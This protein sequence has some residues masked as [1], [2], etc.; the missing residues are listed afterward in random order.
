MAAGD[1]REPPTPDGYTPGRA[2]ESMA[3]CPGQQDITSSAMEGHNMFTR[4][5]VVNRGEPAVRLIRAL[6]EQNEEYAYGSR[7]ISLHT[8]AEQRSHY[9]RSA[10]ESV[11]LREVDSPAGPYLDHEELERALRASRADAVWVGWGFVAEDPAFADL[12]ERL[13]L[14]FIGPSA[15]AMR[16][17]CDRI[18]AR[19]LAER[20][21]V[22]VAPWSGGPVSSP[23]EAARH[24]DIIGYPLLIKATGGRGGRGIRVVRSADEL[25]VAFDRA[26]SEAQAA[27]GDPVVF[28]ER[29]VSDGRNVEVQIIA[30]DHGTVWAPGVRDCSIQRRN[31]WKLVEESRSPALG[32]EQEARLRTAAAALM[33]A[34]GYRGAGTVEFIYQPAEEAFVFVGV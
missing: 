11:C 10:D 17:L 16:Q 26:S 18:E 30:D 19:L 5:A 4:I 34:A 25:R 29:L 27:F 24:G 6:R 32:A 33:H 9:V 22:P 31:N 7:V 12:C 1:R 13:G 28:M 8:D 3:C 15:G 21:G 23:Q 20:T 14:V 2:W